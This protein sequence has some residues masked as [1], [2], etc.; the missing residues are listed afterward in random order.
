M[1]TTRPSCPIC[2]R[3]ASSITI[4][5]VRDCDSGQ[6]IREKG[7]N[8]VPRGQGR[9]AGLVDQMGGDHAVGGG[10]MAGEEG[11]K[12]LAPGSRVGQ[13]A[14]LEAVAAPSAPAV[15]APTLDLSAM[16]L[17]DP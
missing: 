13:G 7:Q 9:L 14:R 10:D 5:D 6:P 11:G 3:A 15:A 12:P 8:L 16:D 1:G 4:E 2:R 17:D